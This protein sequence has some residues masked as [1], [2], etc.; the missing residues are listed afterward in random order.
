MD[1][2][3]IRRKLIAV[4]LQDSRPA[5]SSECVCAG[6]CHPGQ[7]RSHVEVSAFQYSDDSLNTILELNSFC[8]FYCSLGGNG[9]GD[10][11]A[12]ALAKGLKG[13]S[14]LLALT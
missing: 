10:D 8:A 11:G 1:D 3:R 14:N 6:G 12:T 9:L 13:G 5:R 2:V 7:Q 4:L